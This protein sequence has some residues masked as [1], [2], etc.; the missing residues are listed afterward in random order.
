[1]RPQQKPLRPAAS[2]HVRDADGGGE[3]KLEVAP[4]SC[5]RC[6]AC[7]ALCPGVFEIDAKASRVQRDPTPEEKV[8][9]LAARLVCPT[10][11]IR[12]A[13]MDAGTNAGANALLFDELAVGAERVRWALGEIPWNA[14]DP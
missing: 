2:P 10:D 13:G 7:A 4:P 8:F 3:M 11:A 5:T 14:V 9:V 12:I 1:A 6:G